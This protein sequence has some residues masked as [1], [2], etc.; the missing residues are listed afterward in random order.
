MVFVAYVSVGLGS[1]DRERTV[2]KFGRITARTADEAIGICS[3]M[4][5]RL[6]IK[7]CGLEL[8]RDEAEDAYLAWIKAVISPID[9]RQWY[10]KKKSRVKKAAITDH[11]TEITPPD[12]DESEDMDQAI[13]EAGVVIKLEK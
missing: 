2:R 8:Y 4:L 5:K 11:D 7:T 9:P 12:N 6:A 10:Y 1:H 13:K 3:L